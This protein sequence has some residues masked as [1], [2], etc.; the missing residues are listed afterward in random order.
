MKKLAKRTDNRKQTG[1][2]TDGGA[3]RL[4]RCSAS[5]LYSGAFF[6]TARGGGGGYGTDAPCSVFFFSPPLLLQLL[7]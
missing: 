3:K 2:A 1:S 4:P 7:S 5:R 6:Y